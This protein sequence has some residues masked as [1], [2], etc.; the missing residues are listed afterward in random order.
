MA[1]IDACPN[2]AVIL[3][4]KY[5]VTRVTFRVPAVYITYTFHFPFNQCCSCVDTGIIGVLVDAIIPPHIPM[6][7]SFFAAWSGMRVK[8]HH[9]YIQKQNHLFACQD[10]FQGRC[11]P[12]I[13]GQFVLKEFFLIFCDYQK[14]SF[15]IMAKLHKM[16]AW[17]L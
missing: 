16:F 1:R 11:W 17:F 4:D 6:V 2:T 14:S 15:S 7:C 13:Y 8:I 9:V 10:V 12:L 3:D 5:L